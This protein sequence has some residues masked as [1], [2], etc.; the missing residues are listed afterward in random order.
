MKTHFM[1]K[2]KKGV[3]LSLTVDETDIG[4]IDL[5]L[6]PYKDQ[7]FKFRQLRSIRFYFR[8]LFRALIGK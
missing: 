5:F 2:D 7:G 3:T 8:T 4:N 1:G 6:K